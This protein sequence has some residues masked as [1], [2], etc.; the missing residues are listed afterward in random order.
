MSA[1][2]A[3]ASPAKAHAAK[4]SGVPRAQRK[5]ARVQAP[6]SAKEPPCSQCQAE[7]A[8]AQGQ[9]VPP[10][11]SPTPPGGNSSR[12]GFTVGA[13]DDA[14]ER[15]ADRIAHQ[16]MSG[17]PAEVA[18][19][20]AAPK[21]Q[22][23]PAS[24]PNPTHAPAEIQQVLGT[25]GR[26]LDAK[27]RAFFEPRFG[28][29]FSSVRVHADDV[30][31]RSAR[32]LDA[33]AYTMGHHVVF[34]RG[35]YALAA[36]SGRRMLAHE[37][38]HVVQQS[39]SPGSSPR[40][41]RKGGRGPGSCGLL[42][43]AAAT[44][45]GSAA[46]VQIQ[47]KL[48]TRGIV[49]ELEI[50]RAT[51]AMGLGSRKCQPITTPPG[52]ADVAR[53]TS[54][55][56]SVGEIKPY[57]IAQVAGRMQARHYRTRAT[58]SKQRLTGTGSCGRQPAGPDDYAFSFLT[59]G[60]TAAS[61]YTLLTGA[62]SGTENF[63]LY[64]MDPL[65]DLMAKEVGGG[66]IGYWCTLNAAGKKAKEEEKEAKKKKP[67]GG[68][69]GPNVGLGVSIGGSSMGGYNAGVGISV[70]S[71]SAAIGTAGAG[72]AISSD[73]A[74]ASAA[75]VGA[76][77]DSMGAAAA[78]A[79]AGAAN[80]SEGVAAGAAGAGAASG[81]T[82]AGAGVAGVGK[83]QDSI[84]AS[85]GVAGKGE[86]K[87][88]VAASAG[89]AGS[90][91]TEGVVGAGTGSP[92]KP[93]DPQD[94]SGSGADKQAPGHSDEEVMKGS[95]SGNKGSGDKGS[96]DKA[97]S[98]DK[99]S[100]Y[101]SG[102]K[103][104]GSSGQT[105]SGATGDK[106]SGDKSAGS[107]QQQGGTPGTGS[108]G[109]GSGKVASANPLGV[110]VVAPLGTSDAEREKFAQEAAKVSQMLQNAQPQQID[111]LRQLAKNSADKRYLVPASDWVQK[112][113]NVTAGLT[114]EEIDYLKQ[115]DWKPG[116][117]SE[118]DLRKRIQKAL[119]N[120]KKNPTPGDGDKP[121]APKKDGDQGDGGGGKSGAG[122]GPGSG[123]QGQK[124]GDKKGS[125]SKDS[126]ATAGDAGASDRAVAPPPGSNRN[127]AGIF[128]FQILSGITRDG[129]FSAN[130]AVD[131]M[132]RIQDQKSGQ[133]F[134]L[135]GV[136][137]T[138]V[139]KEETPVTI[140]GVRFVQVKFKVFFTNDFW[141]EKNKFYGKGT[142]ESLTDVDMGRRK[143]K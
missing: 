109:T 89:A 88:S 136:N 79:G 129:T 38:A 108:T 130:Q 42:S 12:N 127:T 93:I 85:A 123:A 90:G 60:V 105:G 118:E 24:T 64:S 139:S 68:P 97:G 62:I 102:Q 56:V 100:T 39:H 9:P 46:H 104:S 7:A 16:V 112:M 63:G 33:Q 128:A 3:S 67:K 138:F 107:S 96:G 14:F 6:E 81:S 124:Q 141:S 1:C 99:G 71:N 55:L 125:G 82:S 25:P 54:P 80:E 86:V 19:D 84:T 29:D 51:K 126:Q 74:A 20:A 143:A 32:A 52:F 23:L 121:A 10:P 142:I 47:T 115:L 27:A 4:G 103:G 69:S 91:K 116:S 31:D 87:D 50:P 43:A 113:L 8:L 58:Q 140:K 15:E 57:Y 37:L 75:G 101:G 92:K 72:I 114:Q 41:Q 111:L 35:S 137:I 11:A 110:Y 13:P 133:T 70:D 132:V 76:T 106:G 30:A 78:A 40:V 122:K 21:L 49:P 73:S 26:P 34:A 77:K 134:E 119:T 120:R 98:G 131:C 117:I 94:V 22:R 18:P 65:R 17:K 48:A 61:L 59:G 28:H 2:A 95:G 83:S 44:V 66:A 5:C 45:L 135:D 36:E 53:I